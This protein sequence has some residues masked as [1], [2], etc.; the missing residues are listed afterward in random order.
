MRN[1]V[2]KRVLAAP[3]SL[4]AFAVLGLCGVAHAQWNS[5]G[6]PLVTNPNNQY[7]PV[8]ASDNAGGAIIA[9]A[10]RRVATPSGTRRWMIYAQRVNN[11]GVPQWLADGVQVAADTARVDSVFDQEAP[12][13]LADGAGGAYVAW[14]DKHEFPSTDIYLQH[15]DA[16]GVPAWA[17]SDG[18]LGVCKAVNVQQNPD[19]VSDGASGV[20]VTWQDCRN[21]VN[22]D[23]YAQRVNAAGVPQWAANGVALCTAANSQFRPRAA[24]D[25]NNGAI[26]VWY[27]E[28][29]VNASGGSKDLFAQRVSGAGVPLWKISVPDIVWPDSLNGFPVLGPLG[30]EFAG[31]QQVP[32]LIPD[33]AGGAIIACEDS[34]SALVSATFDIK[35]QRLDATGTQLWSSSGIVVSSAANDQ[36]NPK[37]CSDGAGGA[38]FTWYDYR[39]GA[40]ADADVYANRLNASG[41][42]QWGTATTGVAL[43]SLSGHQ[44]VPQAVTDGAGGGIFVWYDERGTS[45]SLYTQRLNSVGSPQWAANG[46]N[47]CGVPYGA[48]ARSIIS[49]GSGGAIVAW[50]DGR[51]INTDIYAA[52]VDNAGGLGIPNSLLGVGDNGS[53][54]LS[55]AAPRPNPTSRGMSVRFVL[56]VMGP[57]TLELLDVTGRLIEH[58]E[59][60]AFGAGSHVLELGRGAALHAGLYFVRLRQNGRSVYTKATVIP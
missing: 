37:L 7:L 12:A 57:A 6:V 8:T 32:E 2:K 14:V 59:V 11:L 29:Y 18:G 39:K 28:R 49:D 52:R 24:S 21:G 42:L 27:D 54:G 47:I 35:A 23:V 44:L 17:T 46:I 53:G 43:C 55:L 13:I 31:E 45:P 4:A 15:I 30:D 19:L 48:A 33:G 38:I 22:F 60:G 3:L 41:T 1:A 16:A 34:R 5:C 20:I 9:W 50:Q 58:H 10:D 26:V 51:T 36:R 40:N 25:G 56:P